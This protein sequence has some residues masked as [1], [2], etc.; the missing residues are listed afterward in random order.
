MVG[1]GA[2]EAREDGE[3]VEAGE[4]REQLGVLLAG[5]AAVGLGG[6]EEVADEGE[7][8]AADLGDGERGVVD[9]PEGVA[10]DQEDG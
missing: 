1:G 6:D 4:T 7:L 2:S 9:G 10:G 5:E 3:R 8:A